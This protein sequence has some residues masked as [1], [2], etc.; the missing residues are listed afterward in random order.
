M[1]AVFEKALDLPPEAQAAFVMD[2]CADDLTLGRDVLALLG[3][4]DPRHALAIER[5][6]IADAPPDQSAPDRLVGEKIGAYRILHLLGQ[7]GM[8]RVYLAERADG[9]FQQQ[10]AVKLVAAGR[11]WPDMASRVR[12]ERQVLAQ[13]QHPHIARL[14]D[15]GVSDDGTPY[16]VMEYVEGVPI[17]RFCADREVGVAERLRLFRTVCDAVQHAHRSLVVHRDLKPSN[18]LIT[19][20]GAVKLLDF[21][22]AKLLEPGLFGLEVE[23]TRSE[24]RVMTP[25]YA[26][27][28]QLRGEPVTTATDVYALG[29]VLYEL[30][31][32]TRPVT[33]GTTTRE[34]EQALA[35]AAI[36]A[37]SVVVG[38][39]RGRARQIP[40]DLDRIVLMALRP[41]PERRYASAGQLAEDV[42]RYLE[43]RP[44]LAQPDTPTYRLRRFVGRHRGAVAAAATVTIALAGVVLASAWQSRVVALERDAARL[45]R[46]KAQQVVQLLVDLFEATNPEVRPRGDAMTVGEF[47]ATAETQVLQVLQP[48]PV[49]RARLQQVFGSIHAARSQY[50]RARALL[51]GALAD[52]RRLIGSDAPESLDT[53]HALASVTH[54]MGRTDEARQL[55]EESLERNRRVYGEHHP[56]TARALYALA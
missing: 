35:T 49:V 3:L 40:P 43:G 55:L 30:L 28:E 23:R 5:R 27:P 41:E 24:L 26:A 25:E 16:L 21:G 7:G 9:Q 31:T 17:T 32:D 13:L 19:S 51:E 4:D 29:V 11:L 54:Q 18:V 42:A 45:E 50:P 48:Q 39:E 14:I 2:T 33:F 22:I 56:K 34:R 12:I 8:G 15:A 1:Q 20:A 53:L 10:V 6:L 37:P 36:L 38:R 52:E 47:L 44:V 46:D